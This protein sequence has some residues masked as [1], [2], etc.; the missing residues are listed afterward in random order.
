MAF[1]MILLC[2]EKAIVIFILAV[3]G[4]QTFAQSYIENKH[5]WDYEIPRWSFVNFFSSFMIVF[6]VLCGEWIENMWVCMNVAGWPCVPFF[7]FTV[8]IG[9]LMVSGLFYFSQNNFCLKKFRI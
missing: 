8:I 7:L 6:R 9:K 2:S 5:I 3:I 4:Q 1:F